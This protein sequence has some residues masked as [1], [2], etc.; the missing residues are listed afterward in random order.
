M[1]SGYARLVKA[2][3]VCQDHSAGR[4]Y[5]VRYT[6]RSGDPFG[7]ATGAIREPGAVR[8]QRTAPQSLPRYVARAARESGQPSPC[9][10]DLAR[11]LLRWLRARHDW[12][13]R[14]DDEG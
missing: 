9:V 2:S 6:F 12:S 14:L 1:P 10:A 3:N 13:A 4:R 5:S 8:A 11:W 7:T